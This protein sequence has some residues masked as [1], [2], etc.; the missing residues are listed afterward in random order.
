M[1]QKQ[2][3]TSRNR[4]GFTLVEEETKETGQIR[5]VLRRMA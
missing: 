2:L 1:F 5:L 4:Q 3:T